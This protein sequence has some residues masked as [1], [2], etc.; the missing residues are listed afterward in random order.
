MF[1]HKALTYIIVSIITES[2]LN[3]E[4]LTLKTLIDITFFSELDLSK[5]CKNGFEKEA[6]HYL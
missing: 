6:C 3:S 1:A 5:E 2:I 4:S